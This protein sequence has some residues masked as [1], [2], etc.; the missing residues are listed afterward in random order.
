M[1]P[2]RLLGIELTGENIHD[3]AGADALLPRMKA[4]RLLADKAYD[5]DKRV[6]E[7]LEAVE[8]RG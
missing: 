6:I 8:R 2:D 5:V 1:I 7:R 3:L 4:K